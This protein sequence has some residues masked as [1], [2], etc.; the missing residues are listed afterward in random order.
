MSLLV[1]KLSIEYLWLH[2]GIR[3]CLATVSWNVAANLEFPPRLKKKYQCQLWP[4]E[5]LI[6]KSIVCILATGEEKESP[7]CT[8]TV[9]NPCCLPLYN[10]VL[11]QSKSSVHFEKQKVCNLT[12]SCYS[13]FLELPLTRGHN[14]IAVNKNMSNRGIW[15][16]P[17]RLSFLKFP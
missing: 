4:P 17:T 16:T 3:S 6:N 15:T 9:E 5:I 14:T 8:A 10:D 1:P 11:H 7:Q 13:P 12:L 2:S